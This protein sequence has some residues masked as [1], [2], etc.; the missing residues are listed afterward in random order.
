MTPSPGARQPRRWRL[1]HNPVAGA[2][3]DTA[4]PPLV[5]RLLENRGVATLSQAAPSSTA[6]TECDPFA[7]PDMEKAVARLRRRRDRRGGRR[8]RRLRRRRR[9]VG[10]AP[11]RR[12]CAR[13]AARVIPYIPDR[14]DE[15]YG[16]N[17]PAIS[18]LHDAGRH[19]AGR[20]RLRH[21][22]PR[23]G[24]ARA[25]AGHGRR[26]HRPP[27]AADRLPAALA[28]VNPKVAGSDGRAS[29]RLRRPRLLCPAW[30]SSTPCGG[31]SRR[32]ASSTSA[33]LGTVSTW[34]RSRPEPRARPSRPRRHR[35]H[36]A[37][38]RPAGADGGRAASRAR[39]DTE[40]LSFMLGPRLNAAG[41][42]AHARLSLDLLLC[43]EPDAAAT[44][45]QQLGSLNRQRQRQT[46]AAVELAWS[47]LGEDERRAPADDRP[48]RR[49][50]GRRGAG[51]VEAGGSALPPGRHL[52][53]GRDDEPGQRS[54]HPRVRPGGRAARNAATSSCASVG[55]SRRRASPP[56][57]S[58][59]RRSRR[60]HR[61]RRRAAGRRRTDADDRSGR[62]G[63]AA[64][65]WAARRYAGWGGW[66]RTASATR[67]RCS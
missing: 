58:V 64:R 35:P 63:G 10:R 11:D 41:R 62:R 38:L 14:F 36:G 23:R 39:V 65:A 54:Q 16:L 66:R 7:L 37:A 50:A 31:P 24:R 30:P 51:R 52:P 5:Q 42:L 4:F 27:P 53:A 17:S 44:M 55:T 43:D 33:G 26:H 2:L 20:R 48:R 46:A 9:N 67:S 49:P 12:R 25:L 45:A 22:L 19:A 28:L 21:Q 59:C 40:T 1:R 34:R 13:L 56:T 60:A 3:S 6:K 18:R 29:T 32:S 47:L 8:L 15:G 61:L 57:T